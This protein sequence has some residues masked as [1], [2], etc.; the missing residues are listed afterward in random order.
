MKYIKISDRKIIISGI[1]KLFFQDGFPISMSIQEANSCGYEVSIL[2]VADECI[3]NGW[4]GKTTFNKISADFQDD[5]NKNN[6]DF[7]LLKTFCD[8]DYERQREMI[9]QYLYGCDYKQTKERGCES[10]KQFFVK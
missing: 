2:H 1:G 6:F 9:F 10:A 4:S 8:A 5:I 3:K 7:K